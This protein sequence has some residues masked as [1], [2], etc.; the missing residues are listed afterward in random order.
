MPGVTLER[1][2][3][4]HRGS[5]GGDVVALRDVTLEVEDGKCL[6]V[7]GPSGSGKTTLLRLM[8]GLEEPTSGEMWMGGRSL[9]GVPGRDRG[10]AMV[11]QDHP[12][13]PHLD[14][15]GNL[16]LGLQLRRVS[17]GE[18]ATRLAEAMEWLELEA[19]RDRMPGTLSGGERQRVAL[20]MALVQRPAV[21]LLDEPLAHLDAAWRLPLRR[22][23]RR[24]QRRLGLTW[25]QVTHD[26]SEALGLADRLVVLESGTVQQVGTPEDVYG[27]P[28]NRFVGA[29]LGAPGMNLVTGTWFAS[30][31]EGWR[32][33]LA[34]GAIW[35]AEGGVG[36]CAPEAVAGTTRVMGVRP[37]VVRLWEPGAAE[38]IG[39]G[40][41]HAMGEIGVVEPLGHETWV[42]VRVG[43][44]GWVVARTP[45]LDPARPGTV[46]RVAVPVPA[47]HWFDAATGR[48]VE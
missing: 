41:V 30:G 7:V 26:Q 34:C 28:A 9:R 8:A 12:L 47:L 22:E 42:H 19:L 43:V 36:P 29:F 35:E 40:W 2:T 5:R 44:D 6:V 11:F 4:I 38:G 25:V 24:L 32:L 31:A 10:V 3:K 39:A 1:V 21:L 18:Q 15:V 13:F 48:R 37:E 14:V 27:R 46:V 23:L 33:R 16:A 20:G 45:G 17:K